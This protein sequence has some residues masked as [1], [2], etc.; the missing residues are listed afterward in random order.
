MY[1][2]LVDQA[3][4]LV[5]IF[6][7]CIYLGDSGYAQFNYAAKRLNRRLSQLGG[8]PVVNVGLA[9]D[10]H[11]LGQDFVIDPWVTGFWKKAL[12]M[13][14]LP[15]GVTPV[16]FDILPPPKYMIDFY[17]IIAEEETVIVETE[18]N[19]SKEIFDFH[20]PYMATLIS[21]NR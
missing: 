5:F 3:F 2:V 8:N 1:Y 10:Q 20:H 9:D 17:D 12:E 16:S 13:F 19:N 7:Y 4:N 18:I 15:P 11:D 14:P 6:I 21:N